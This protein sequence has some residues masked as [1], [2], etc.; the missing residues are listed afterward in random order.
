MIFHDADIVFDN[1]R[2][3]SVSL[4]ID[5]RHSRYRYLNS[6][7]ANRPDG[8]D[9]IIVWREELEDEGLFRFA[10]LD[11]TT[12]IASSQLILLLISKS[13]PARP[14]IRCCNKVMHQ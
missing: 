9:F 14:G 8:G 7:V 1:K 10:N 6:A 11:T 3:P 13:K 4:A 12:F 5:E 2:F